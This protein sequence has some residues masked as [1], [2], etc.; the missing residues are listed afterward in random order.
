MDISIIVVGKN[1]GFKLK[2]CFESIAACKCALKSDYNF[3]TIYVDSDS[4]DE[5]IQLAADYDIDHVLKIK[6]NINSAIARNVGAKYARHDWFFFVDGDMEINAGF[7]QDPITKDYL[8][9]ED[10]FSGQFI[11]IFYDE[12]WEKISEEPYKPNK[13]VE[14]QLAPGG[15][16]LVRK[17]IWKTLGG[18]KDYYKRSQDFEFGLRCFKAG[19]PF[20]R[21]N[22]LLVRHHT[23]SYLNRSRVIEFRKGGYHLYSRSLLYREH[24]FRHFNTNCLKLMLRQDYTLIFLSISILTIPFLRYYSGLVYVFPVLLKCSKNIKVGILN[25]LYYIIS[26]DF[27]VFMGILFFYPNKH[28]NYKLEVIK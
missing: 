17:A 22:K 21:I 18:M 23:I 11:N 9:R 25:Y 4:N 8:E 7:F 26:R 1:E 6:G 15:L 5:S 3:Q 24:I 19:H 14:E 2:K 13:T 27:T 10:F 12:S 28:P 16:F 20:K